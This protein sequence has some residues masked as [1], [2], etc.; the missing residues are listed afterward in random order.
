[1]VA[2]LNSLAGLHRAAL[3]GRGLVVQGLGRR[4]QEVR[5]K[6]IQVFRPLK[7]RLFSWLDLVAGLVFLLFFR[8]FFCFLRGLLVF[9][10]IVGAVG[11]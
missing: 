2:N 8:V 10:L 3:G 5:L 6:P 1:L 9:F 4:K 7:R 11:E